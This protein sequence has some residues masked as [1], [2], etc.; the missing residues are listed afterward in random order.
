[1]YKSQEA[2]FH[3]NIKKCSGACINIE[4]PDD[5]N[6]RVNQCID[7]LTFEGRSFY[8]IDKGRE[9]VEKSIVW[10]EN[11][12]YQG[13][14]FAPYHFHGKGPDAFSRYITKQKEDR[15]IKTILNLF[16][17]KN[18]WAKIIEL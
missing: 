17:R 9:K 7:A 6:K 11:G 12:V 10:I 4:Q 13:Y 3:Y 8:I 2:C 18:E 15:D 1:M 14:G 16:L 5:Y